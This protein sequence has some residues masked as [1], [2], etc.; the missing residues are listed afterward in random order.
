MKDRAADEEISLFK[1]CQQLSKEKSGYG[2]RGF[3]DLFVS[4]SFIAKQIPLMSPH[5]LVMLISNRFKIEGMHIE[6]LT[7]LSSEYSE[8]SLECYCRFLSIFDDNQEFK[9]EAVTLS[10]IHQA[11]GQEWAFV[12]I[13]GMNEGVIPS[14]FNTN[15]EEERRLAYVACT[16]SKKHLVISCPCLLYTSPSPRDS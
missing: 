13:A 15:L 14:S 11:K 16:R 4:V 3:T 12:V 9:P 2:K 1:A 10:T 5:D 8:A 7:S 6:S